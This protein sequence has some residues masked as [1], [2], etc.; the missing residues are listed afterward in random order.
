MF[1]P[2][3][4]AKVQKIK[5][6][7]NKSCK[8]LQFFNMI[9]PVHHGYRKIV[10]ICISFISMLK[11]GTLISYLSHIGVMIFLGYLVTSCA[12][13]VTPKGGPKDTDPPEVLSTEPPNYSTFFNQKNIHITFNE[14]VQLNNPVNQILISPPLNKINDYK[15]KGKTM[16]IEFNDSLRK[17]TTYTLFFGNAISDITENNPLTN[18]Q[19]T[20]STGAI[21]DSLSYS[22]SVINAFDLSP[23]EGAWVLLYDRDIDSLPYLEKPVYI[24]KTQTDGSFRFQNL[25]SGSFKIFALHESDNNYIY[26]NPGETI[27]F[28]DTLINPYT[29][30]TDTTDSLADSRDKQIKLMMFEEVDSIQ[31]IVDVRFIRDNLVR[32]IFAFPSKEPGF[33]ILHR[34]YVNNWILPEYN[35]GKDTINL[36]ITQIAEDTLTFE[37]RDI[38]V[39]DTV[40]ITMREYAASKKEEEKP[41]SRLKISSSA[42]KSIPHNPF[43]PLMLTFD[44]PVTDFNFDEISV[45]EGSDTLSPAKIS[46]LSPLRR[47]ANI[48]FDWKENFSYQIIIPDS[49]FTGITGSQNDSVF[50][51]FKTL[52]S[53]DYGELLLDIII[54]DSTRQYILQLM[55][56]DNSITRQLTVDKSRQISFK[57][58]E[59]GKYLIKV[60]TD[61]NRNGKWDTGIYLENLQPEKVFYFQKVLDIRPN[62]ISQETLQFNPHRSD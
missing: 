7:G 2:H 59:G 61:S 42:T 49:L 31:R 48:E 21:L 32:L 11:S 43:K 1:C 44:Y 33:K 26:D 19:Y 24:S 4:P 12:N 54:D 9:E 14:Y 36:W 39:L 60:I 15:L 58:L 20:F 57:Y 13:P 22:G 40:E 55:K 56:E 47:K 41:V 37:I 51:T 34:D 38:E 6:S 52:S 35:A 45:I 27:A 28:S 8:G 46:F 23:I 10:H 50:I 25:G 16:I 17:E 53:A 30:H 29:H 3:W 5:V 18:F 62:W